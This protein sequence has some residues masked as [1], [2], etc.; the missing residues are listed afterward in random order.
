MLLGYSTF[1][2]VSVCCGV[3][4]LEAYETFS[5]AKCQ[6]CAKAFRARVI[7]QN[8]SP[9]F[10]KKNHKR[11]GSGWPSCLLGARVLFIIAS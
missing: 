11:L 8:M 4:A 2:M 10:Y 6:E 7:F 1:G 9:A 3:D 5:I